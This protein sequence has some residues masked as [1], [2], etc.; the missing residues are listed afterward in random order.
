[1]KAP[2]CRPRTGITEARPG[3]NRKNP[4][5]IRAGSATTRAAIPT[6]ATVMTIQS[7]RSTR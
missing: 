5:G 7:M 4:V 2:D 1:M 6:T 3:R